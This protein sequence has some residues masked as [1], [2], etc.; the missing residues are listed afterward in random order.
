VVM[1]SWFEEEI[2]RRSPTPRFAILR[3]D[4]LDEKSFTL[5]SYEQASEWDLGRYAQEVADAK[6]RLSIKIIPSINCV[7]EEGWVRAAQ[8]MERASLAA[9]QAEYFARHVGGVF[10]GLVT[11]VIPKGLFVEIVNTGAR[12]FLPAEDLGA[13]YFDRV[14]HAFVE[15]SGAGLWRPGSRMKVKVIA[16]DE[17]MGRIDLVPAGEE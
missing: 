17:A 1:K 7:T 5:F 4:L 14:L 3:H 2:S 8:E 10:D 13:V 15:V 9:R 16:A 6:A 11:G 12:G